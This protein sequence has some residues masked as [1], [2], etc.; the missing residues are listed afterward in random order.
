MPHGSRKR[1]F[2][3]ERDV[4]YARPGGTPLEMTLYYPPEAKDPDALDDTKFP[5]MVVLHGGAWSMGTRYQQAWYCREFARCGFVVMTIDYRMLPDYAFPHCL[6]DAKSAVRWLRLHADEYRVHPDY[7]A[8]FGASSGGHLAAFLA[9]TR[10]EDGFEGE[11]NPGVSSRVGAAISLYGAVDL[12]FYRDA[13]EKGIDCD[14]DP[15]VVRAFVD[16]AGRGRGDAFETASPI[17]YIHE[18][19]APVLLIHGTNDRLVPIEQSEAFYQRLCQADAHGMFTM[20]PEQEHG[21]DYLDPAKRDEAFRGML[22]FL[23]EYF[24]ER[25][26]GNGGEFDD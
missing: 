17:T 23:N 22:R 13:A 10:P 7:I 20:L 4:V 9:V 21:F 8:A 14:A 19:M 1:P 2:K 24:L 12:T 16:G 11:E 15:D 26:P 5:G 25:E 18:A 3:T 6:H